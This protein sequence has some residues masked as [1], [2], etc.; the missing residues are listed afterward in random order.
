MFWLILVG[1]ISLVVVVLYFIT[2]GGGNVNANPYSETNRSNT[3]L[4]PITLAFIPIVASIIIWLV[5]ASNNASDAYSRA[6]NYY[7][8][9]SYNALMA[10]VQNHDI[11]SL[12]YASHLQDIGQDSYVNSYATRSYYASMRHNWFIPTIGFTISLIMFFHLITRREN[13]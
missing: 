3:K 8:R 5:L 1:V 6:S 9:D 11:A 2:R 4:L 12:A 13:N 10:G 7:S